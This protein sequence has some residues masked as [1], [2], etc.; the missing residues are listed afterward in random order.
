MG[1]LGQVLT[2]EKFHWLLSNEMVISIFC[3][4]TL[5]AR[6]DFGMVSGSQQLV[7]LVKWINAV[8]P[9]F[10]LPLDTSEEELRA[11]LRDGS[12]LCSILDNLVPGSVKVVGVSFIVFYTCVLPFFSFPCV[13]A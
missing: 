4:P 12:V 10:N 11:W 7:S 6:L 2:E 3:W 13:C 8:L 9:N 1:F 5:Y